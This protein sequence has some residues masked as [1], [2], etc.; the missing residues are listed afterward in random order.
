M[1][2]TALNV[3]A[4]VVIE[5]SAYGAHLARAGNRGPFA[6]P[7]GLYP[8]RSAD[9]HENWLALAIPDNIA[10]DGYGDV[11]GRP[12]GWISPICNRR[13]ADA[14]ATISSTRN[15]YAGV[16]STRGRQSRDA[17]ITHGVPAARVVEPSRVVDNPQMR[18]R[19]FV[20]SFDHPLV[21]RHEAVGL[22]FRL[23][24]YEGPWLRSP[25]PT[26]GQHNEEVLGAILGLTT[27]DLARLRQDKV[28]GDHPFS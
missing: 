6:A 3:A 13:L 19:N 21:G 4:E 23:A 12:A 1:V 5:H 8:C 17:L 28:I 26:L 15:S 25:A 27:K 22:P 11:L 18:S 24:S 20:E 16:K 10:W 2:E 7:Q 9:S 14:M